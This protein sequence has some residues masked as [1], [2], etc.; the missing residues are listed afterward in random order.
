[1]KGL[2]ASIW[3]QAYYLECVSQEQKQIEHSRM[4]F[5]VLFLYEQLGY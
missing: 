3:K 5:K 2:D 4:L 1:M